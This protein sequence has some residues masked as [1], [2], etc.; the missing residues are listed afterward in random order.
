[1]L[2]EFLVRD[3]N[4]YDLYNILSIRNYMFREAMQ[5]MISNNFVKNEDLIALIHLINI[6]RKDFKNLY[7]IKYH[8]F[9]RTLSGAYITMRPHKYMKLSPQYAINDLRALNLELADIA[10]LHMYLVKKSMDIYVKIV[11]L[12]F[13]KTMVIMKM[14]V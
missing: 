8:T 11:M 12:I 7:D 2:F 9:I 6:A 10:I 3:K 13:M 5:L 14:L 1:M 4:I